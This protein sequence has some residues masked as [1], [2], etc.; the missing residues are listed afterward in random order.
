MP[1]KKSPTEP[2]EMFN[3]NYMRLFAFYMEVS[4]SSY[5]PEIINLS[6]E[7]VLF[8]LIAIVEVYQA[9]VTRHLIAA[10]A[11]HISKYQLAIMLMLGHKLPSKGS[12]VTWDELLDQSASQWVHG[13]LTKWIQD[14]IDNKL[15]SKPKNSSVDDWLQFDEIK[16]TRNL[17]AH[18]KGR[19]DEVYIKRTKQYYAIVAKTM[20]P[21]LNTERVI[22]PQYCYD[23]FQCCSKVIKSIDDEIVV[24]I[25]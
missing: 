4:N 3:E 10:K 17:L 11:N 12:M 23:A 7:L 8:Q 22:N 6:K 15:I 19:V 2:F 5:K 20:A 21:T 13:N 1:K 25:T 14:L 9:D 18:C 16:A 24:A